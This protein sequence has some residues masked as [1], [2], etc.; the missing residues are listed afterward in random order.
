MVGLGNGNE[1]FAS[2]Q[3]HLRILTVKVVKVTIGDNL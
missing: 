2:L 1:T 3:T